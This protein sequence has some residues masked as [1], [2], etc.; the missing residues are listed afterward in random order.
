MQ[1]LIRNIQIPKMNQFQFH[2]LSEKVC[3][4]KID[5]KQELWETTF[6]KWAMR[7]ISIKNVLLFYQMP[8][9]Q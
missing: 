3:D 5:N 9:K 6:I 7:R 2:R 1:S 4:D 8:E